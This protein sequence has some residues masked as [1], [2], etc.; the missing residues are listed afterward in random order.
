MAKYKIANTVFEILT[1]SDYTQKLCQ[2][3]L[4]EENSVAE[5]TI[6]TT[7]EEVREY[8]KKEPNFPGA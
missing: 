8:M 4:A 6:K 7:V 2:D 3:Y 1:V 5:F